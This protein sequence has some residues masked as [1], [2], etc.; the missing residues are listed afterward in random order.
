VIGGSTCFIAD[1]NGNGHETGL[2]A[3]MGRLLATL[4][5]PRPAN[6]TR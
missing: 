4:K 5:G 1:H 3:E 2:L 6:T